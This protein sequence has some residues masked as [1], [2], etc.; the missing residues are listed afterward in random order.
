MKIIYISTL[1]ILSCG[2]ISAKE[3][4][5]LTERDGSAYIGYDTEPESEAAPSVDGLAEILAT[6][7]KDIPIKHAYFGAYFLEDSR[8]QDELLKEFKTSYPV[9]LANA[10]KSSGN[11]HNPEVHPLRLKFS[12]CLLKTP[13]LSKIN[14]VLITQGY[15]VTGIQSEKFSINKEQQTPRFHAIIWLMIE[16]QSD[17]TKKQNKAEMATPRKPSD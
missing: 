14:E 3:G 15:S 12:E 7:N 5:S 1:A 11:M 16:P 6:R 9:L 17:K 8:V 13:T 10:L 4:W 2:I